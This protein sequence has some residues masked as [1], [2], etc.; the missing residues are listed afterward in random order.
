MFGLKNK[1]RSATESYKNIWYGGFLLINIVLC[2]IMI[3]TPLAPMFGLCIGTISI[4]MIN[5]FYIDFIKR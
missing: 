5:D 2:F 4:F 3:P 1:H